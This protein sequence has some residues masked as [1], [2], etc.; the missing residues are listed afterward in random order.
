MLKEVVYERLHGL[1]GRGLR[2]WRTSLAGLVRP[3]IKEI[4]K[5]S[6]G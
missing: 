2:A 4:E 3:G 5:V 1:H 6:H